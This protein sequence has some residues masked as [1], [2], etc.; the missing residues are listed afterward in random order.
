MNGKANQIADNLITML[1]CRT[2]TH[3][4]KQPFRNKERSSSR[5][6]RKTNY[7]NKRSL[8]PSSKY[9]SEGIY[10]KQGSAELL[11]KNQ[12]PASNDYSAR[13]NGENLRRITV[14]GKYNTGCQKRERERERTNTST[15]GWTGC[16]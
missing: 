13:R 3:L 1:N 14:P 6:K 4:T 9:H 12:Q 11:K 2:T 16:W 15:G 5:S 8:L 10:Q 7:Q